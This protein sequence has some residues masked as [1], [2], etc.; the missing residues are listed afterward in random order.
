MER[1]TGWPRR[2]RV[3]DSREAKHAVATYRMT[4]GWTHTPEIRLAALLAPWFHRGWCLAAL[5]HAAEF[6]PDHERQDIADAKH[7]PLGSLEIKLRQWRDEDGRPLSPPIM[8]LSADEV[9][10]LRKQRPLTVTVV[11]EQPSREAE[12]A[13]PAEPAPPK[14]AQADAVTVDATATGPDAASKPDTVASEATASDAI[15]AKPASTTAKA[16]RTTRQSA[17]EAKQADAPKKTESLGAQQELA[18]ATEPPAERAKKSTPKTRP[19]D[20]Q[21]ADKQTAD[22]QSA[23]KAPQT[24]RAP[25]KKRASTA[26]KTTARKPAASRKKAA[27]SKKTF[28]SALS[29]MDELIGHPTPGTRLSEPDDLFTNEF[30]RQRKSVQD[31]GY[32]PYLAELVDQVRK[33][34]PQSLTA[35]Q[36]AVLRARWRSI[37]GKRALSGLDPD[38]PLN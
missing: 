31:S 3:S 25:A 17:T 14:L 29:E 12:I 4:A 19:S 18:T 1:A 33:G 34:G 16:K 27:E 11:D 24:T 38:S 13:S 36:R 2:Q 21:A 22:K 7:D 26:K 37:R 28:Q 20:K 23:E 9:R 35:E 10:E 8:A 5:Y 32:E 15:A 30:Q 6:R